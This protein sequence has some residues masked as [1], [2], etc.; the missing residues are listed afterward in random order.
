MLPVAPHCE[1][2]SSG[3]SWLSL[4]EARLAVGPVHDWCVLPSCGAVVVFSGTVRDHADHRTGVTMLE[5]EAYEAQVVPK[6][7]V[8]EYEIRT[9]FDEIGRVAL[10]HRVGPLQLGEVSVVIGVSSAHRP[11]A[12]EA[13]RFGIDALKATVPIWKRETWDGGTDWGLAATGLKDIKDI[14]DIKDFAGVAGVVPGVPSIE[15]VNGS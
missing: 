12:F 4:T 6:L 3:D 15:A 14:K 8:I 11:A 2:P 1:P 13:A 7:T 5:Y 10:L 9:R